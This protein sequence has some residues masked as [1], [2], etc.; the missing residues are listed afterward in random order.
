MLDKIEDAIIDLKAGKMIIVVDDE[1]RENEGDFIMPAESI[2]ADDVNFMITYGRGL[3]CAP[4]KLEIAKKLGLTPMVASP[5]DSMQ[6]A[7]TISVDA[8]E[9]ITTGISTQDRAKTLRLL[10]DESSSGD[11]IVKP[12]HIFPLIAKDEGVLV[13]EGHTEAAV[14][15][16]LL[17]GHS[18]VGVICEILSQ[19]GS[20]ARLPELREL[21]KKYNLK[22]ISIADL[23]IYRQQESCLPGE[24]NEG[25][26]R[27][28]N[29]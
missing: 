11:D 15:L 21:A 23:V 24:K 8:K 5:E 16:A 2:T 22:L 13:R 10:G 4:M 9:N 3:V 26:E 25:S 19:D 28:A 7:F 17:S 6:T 18:P 14:D 27:Q 29:A 1:D 20:A 12:G